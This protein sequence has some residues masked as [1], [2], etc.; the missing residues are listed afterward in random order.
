[1]RVSLHA[2]CSDVSDGAFNIKILYMSIMI[3][4]YESGNLWKVAGGWPTYNWTERLI[5]RAE[6]R[7]QFNQ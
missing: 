7:M 6:L 2:F 5:V 1:M 3:E 4:L